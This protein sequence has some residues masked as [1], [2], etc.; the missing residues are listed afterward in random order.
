VGYYFSAASLKRI[1]DDLASRLDSGGEIVAVHWRGESKDHLLHGDEVHA[2]L[3]DT[4][5]ARCHWLK[6]ER[7]PEFRLDVWRCR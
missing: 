4:L 7:Y 6:G 5:D 1:I 3:K 2:I